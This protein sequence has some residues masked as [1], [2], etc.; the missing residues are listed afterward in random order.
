MSRDEFKSLKEALEEFFRQNPRIG[1]SV[2]RARVAEAWMELLD[3]ESKPY[4]TR[5]RF[6][7]GT[8]FVKVNSAPLRENLDRQKNELLQRLN[9]KLGEPLVQKIVIS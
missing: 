6:R 5:I 2:T 9:E 3:A 8:L 1:R 7:G 4:M